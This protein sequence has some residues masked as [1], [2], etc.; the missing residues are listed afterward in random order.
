[1]GTKKYIKVEIARRTI[2]TVVDSSDVI[3]IKKAAEILHVQTQ[4]VSRLLD[5]GQLPW[6]QDISSDDVPTGAQ[7]QRYTLL[8]AVNDRALGRKTKREKKDMSDKAGGN[9]PNSANSDVVFKAKEVSYANT[10]L[11][12]ARA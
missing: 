10:N 3:T 12:G 7:P 6:I 9:S 8:S 4:A 11:V 1:M 5:I 2:K